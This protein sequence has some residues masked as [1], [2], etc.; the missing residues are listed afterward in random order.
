MIFSFE[1]GALKFKT[2]DKAKFYEFVTSK[3]LTKDDLKRYLQTIPVLKYYNVFLAD[4]CTGLKF[5]EIKKSTKVV[6][7]IIEAQNL[8][9]GYKDA[10]TYTFVGDKAYYQPANDVVNMPKIDAFITEA[11]Y[12]CTFFHE[13][14]HSTGAKKRLARDFSGKFGSKNYAYEE[15]IAELGAVFLCSEAGILFHTVDNSAKYLKGW[16][17]RLITALDDD[18]KFFLKASAQSKKAVNYILN[19]KT[20]DVTVVNDVVDPKLQIQKE[21]SKVIPGPTLKVPVRR[22]AKN[23]SQLELFSGLGAT[24]TKEPDTIAFNKKLIRAIK[25]GYGNDEIF[26][27]GYPK[28]TLKKYIENFEIRILGNVLTKATTQKDG[29]KLN[30]GNFLDLP[31]FINNPTAI[32]NSK[33]TGYVVLTEI[34]DVENNPV[35][36]ALHINKKFQNCNI[37]SMYVK[38]NFDIYKTWI[39]QGLAIYINKKSELSTVTPAPIA[40]AVKNSHSKDT[41]NNT[42][43]TNSGKK[44]LNATE[45]KPKVT[46][47]ATKKVAKVKPVTTVPDLNKYSTAYNQ[48][49]D[50]K[51]INDNFKFTGDL[52]K[53][54]GNIEIKPVHS[55]AITL[56]SAEGGGKTHT[57]F[58]WAND[59]CNAGYKPI[60][61]S[62]EEHKTSSLSI[63]KAK[64][65]FKGDNIKKIAVESENDGE[66][67]KETYDRLQESCNDFDIVIIDSWA[68]IV[69]MYS[70]AQFDLDFRKK[71]NGKLFIV[72]FQRTSTG[73]MRGG[74]KS[75][76]DGDI[77][78]KG[79]VDRDNFKNNYVFNHKNR[80]NNYSPISDLKYSPALQKLLPVIKKNNTID[81]IS[82]PKVTKKVSFKVIN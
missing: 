40:L 30:W 58:Q 54:L 33:T 67:P 2:S 77:I 71:F 82:K 79:F 39:K 48:Q 73:A 9:D 66:T 46:V 47:T 38:T 59:F 78:L 20:P 16:N 49:N 21:K 24:T 55:I 27:L 36:V 8:I 13:I 35:M 52:K 22:R 56:D 4:D 6:N 60:I 28:D 43:K 7:P 53:L 72:I 12:Y 31:D 32:F 19:V 64:K 15:L 17:K 75:G 5:P 34:K 44:G 41:K 51:V 69:E 61:W 80:Y 18:N 45:V 74:A 23:K 62:L 50:V 57:V 3:G 1:K 26:F 25:K 76:F 42:T 63:D 37:A 70:K 10:P 81:K 14:V 65:Y 68:K 29:H 11:S